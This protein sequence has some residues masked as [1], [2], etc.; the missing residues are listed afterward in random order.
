MYIRVPQI[1]ADMVRKMKN[2]KC[3]NWK[4]KG[5]N[6]LDVDIQRDNCADHGAADYFDKITR[7]MNLVMMA[8]RDGK[9][10]H[11]YYHRE[12]EGWAQFRGILEIAGLP[13]S[14]LGCRKK[15]SC[16]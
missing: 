14:H 4:K 11:I 7:P 15:Q 6:P 3:R 13:R 1:T 2:K 9:D 16:M 12:R 5:P 8:V 10:C